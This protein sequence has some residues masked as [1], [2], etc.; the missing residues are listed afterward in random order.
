M[1]SLDD[2]GKGE[3]RLVVVNTAYTYVAAL[4]C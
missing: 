4:C 1:D 2:D 3:D